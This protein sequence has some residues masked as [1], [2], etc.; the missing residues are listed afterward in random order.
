MGATLTITAP[1]KVNLYLAVGE[2]RGDGYHDVTTVLHALEFHDTVTIAEGGPFSFACSPDLGL[3]EDANL[4]VRAARAM[5]ERYGRPL[6]CT[7]AVAKRIPA[8]GGLGGASSD[9]AAVL[10]GLA[11]LWRIDVREPTVVEIAR[12]LGADVPFFLEGGAALFTGRGD[13]LAERL[14]PLDA[15][16]VLVKPADPVPTAAA[17]AAFDRLTER[18]APV[19]PQRLARALDAGDAVAVG[20]TLFNAMTPASVGM[21]PAIGEALARL[22]GDPA[23]LGAAMAGSG[24][25]VFAICTDAAAAARLADAAREAGFWAEKTRLS[26]RGCVASGE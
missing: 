6:D 7:I 20:S 8:G 9:A 26:P 2:L 17:Y 13:V 10:V 14:T 4:A 22:V 16:V 1:A 3:A 24:S 21:V 15:P 12:A 23:V 25:T 19:S 11:R 5:S 18:P